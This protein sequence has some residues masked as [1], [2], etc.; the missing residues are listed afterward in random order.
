MACGWSVEV[1]TR[2]HSY[3]H[4]DGLPPRDMVDGIRVTRIYSRG[5]HRASSVLYVL[6]GLWHLMRSGRRGIY[7]AHDEGASAW[8]AILARYLLGGRCL[9][10]LRT[11]SYLYKK[12]L[13]SIPSRWRLLTVL[14]LADR[15]VVVNTEVERM[16]RDL[17]LPEERIIRI[18][19]AVDTSRFHPAS[20]EQSTAAR[21]RLGLSSQKMVCLYVGRLAQYKSVDLLLRAWSLLPADI[22]AHAHLLL[23]GDGPER[24]NLA[25]MVVSLGIRESVLMVGMQEAVRDYYWAADIFVL[26]SETE[27]LSNA[28]LEAMACGL[29]AVASSA[30]GAPDLIEEGI[31]GKLFQSGNH[32]QLAEKL[33]EIV[34]IRNRWA[35]MGAQAR[36]TV[37]MSTSQDIVVG[38]VQDL[39]HQLSE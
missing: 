10:K 31:N 18:P 16:L 30:G 19:N 21:K 9:V 7:H 14:R 20:V 11:G 4:P 12:L 23:V 13:S 39:Y 33:N 27:G 28:L 24:T 8:L 15:L 17:G 34:S 35:E 36:Q 5:M 3:A 6:G 37:M 2:R 38:Q 22:H 29:P 1:I 26:P 25:R 32:R